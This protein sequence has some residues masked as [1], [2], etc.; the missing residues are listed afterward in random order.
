M[1]QTQEVGND[2]DLEHEQDPSFPW[3]GHMEDYPK[4]VHMLL[5]LQWN[6]RKLL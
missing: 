1:H 6:I 3:P 4:T 5:Q 2:C